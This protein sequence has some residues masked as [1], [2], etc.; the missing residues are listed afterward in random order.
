MTNKIRVLIVD[1]SPLFVKAIEEIL[2]TEDFEVVGT[3]YDAFDAGDKLIKLKPDV[4]TLDVEM[5]KMTGIEFLK[6]LLP[7]YPVPVVMVSSASGSVFDAINA[8]AVDFV[9]KPSGLNK[10]NISLFKSELITKIKIASIAVLGKKTNNN[11]NTISRL[12]SPQK[13]DIIIAMGASTGGTEAIEQILRAFPKEMPG[14][15]IVQHMPPVFT[16][17]YAKRL[18]SIC[19]MEIVEASDGD[20]ILPGKVLIAPGGKQLSISKSGLKPTVHCYNGEKVNGLAPSVD[21]TFNSMADIIGGRSLGVLLT[22]MGKDGAKG[23]LEM[24]KKGAYTIAQDEKSCIVYGMP[25]EAIS[26]GAAKKISPLD[27]IAEEIIK[28]LQNL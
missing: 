26:L 23:L 22:G 28:A 1:D 11:V 6:L 27:N 14:I 21:V 16:Q 8:G 3:S 5:P 7:K 20:L 19:E 10:E 12:N 13:N 17:I 24:K 4:V 18:N 15:V 2:N 9:E 25:K